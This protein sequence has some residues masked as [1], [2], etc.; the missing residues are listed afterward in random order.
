MKK[1]IDDKGNVVPGLFRTSLGAIVVDNEDSYYKYKETVN[2]RL[3]EKKKIEDL[4]AK[5]QKLETILE[6]LLNGKSNT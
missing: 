1:I 2:K 5:V 4:E 6:S 3:A